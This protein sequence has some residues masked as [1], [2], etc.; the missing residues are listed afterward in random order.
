[1]R[2]EPARMRVESSQKRVEPTLSMVRLQCHAECRF[3]TLAGRK[4]VPLAQVYI[5]LR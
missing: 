5:V 4:Y 2:V 1:M 3:G